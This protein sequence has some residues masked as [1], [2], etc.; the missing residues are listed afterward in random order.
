MIK[1]LY[2]IRGLPGSGKSTLAAKLAPQFCICEADDFF[3]VDGEYKYSKDKIK[4]AHNYCHAKCEDLLNAGEPVVCVSNTFV[5]KWEMQH[6]VD[7]AEHY[8]YTV[9]EI[10]CRGNFNNV[11]GVPAEIIDR[12]RN[13][14]EV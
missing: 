10:I 5:R 1:T 11:H 4:E 7:C 9:V 6:Y 8:G 2:L 14:F 12:M 13:N 3:M